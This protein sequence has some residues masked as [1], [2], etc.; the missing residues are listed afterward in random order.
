MKNA[1][2]WD[3]VPCRSF[4]NRLFGRTYRLHLQGRKIGERG[5]SVSGWLQNTDDVATISIMPEYE[6]KLEL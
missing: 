4:V 1:T 2:F 3:M 5:T 6:G